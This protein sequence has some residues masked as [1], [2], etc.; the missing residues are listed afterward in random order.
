MCD[1]IT[2]FSTQSLSKAFHALIKSSFCKVLGSLDTAVPMFPYLL[3][4]QTAPQ[5]PQ[6]SSGSCASSPVSRSIFPGCTFCMDCPDITTWY[7]FY[8]FGFFSCISF[9]IKPILIHLT[10]PSPNSLTLL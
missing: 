1:H 4:I 2:R 10:T 7:T 8:A 9:Y 3:P 5:G 6:L